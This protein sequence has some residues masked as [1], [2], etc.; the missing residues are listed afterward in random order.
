VVSDA[1]EVGGA[2]AVPAGR[3]RHL[4]QHGVEVVA[5]GS[6]RDPGGGVGVDEQRADP[7]PGAGGEV[8]DGGD[9]GHHQVPLLTGGGAEVEAGREVGEDPRLELA[10]GDRRPH[11]ADPGPR[12]HV[13]VHAPDVVARLVHPCLARLA[14]GTGHEA[15]VVALQHAVEP[16]HDRE[17][18]RPQQHLGAVVHPPGG[19]VRRHDAAPGRR[20]STRGAGTTERMRAMIVSASTPSANA[21]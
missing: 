10:V 19:T 9:G 6:C 11:V 16:P 21:S 7:V 20:A 15:L 12:G 13:P 17:L 5:P 1:T 8:A 2:A 3:G 18:E 14:A 4:V